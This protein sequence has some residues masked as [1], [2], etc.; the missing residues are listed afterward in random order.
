MAWTTVE[1]WS[2]RVWVSAKGKRTFFIRAVMNGKKYGISTGCS[3][4]RAAL[5][6]L[7]KFERDPDSYGRPRSSVVLN[8]ALIDAYEKWC[9]EQTDVID[10]NWLK[11]KR[12]HLLWWGE[13]FDL[14]PLSNIKLA[15]ILSCL[16]GQSS[17][18]DRIKSIK[19]LYSWLRQTDRIS[20]DQDP[21][22]DAL[23][24]PQSQPEQ[25]ATG[26]SKAIDEDDF[27]KVLPLLPPFVADGCVVQSGTGCHVTEVLRLSKSGRVEERGGSAPAIHFLHKGKHIHRLEVP[28]EVADAAKRLIAAKDNAPTRDGYYKA[29]ARAC[30]K[31]G[32]EP[33]TPGR[34]RHTFATNAIARGVPPHAVALALGHRGSPTTLKW[35]ATTAVV[36]MV[37]G[38]YDVRRE[39]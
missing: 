15:H 1:G 26:E 28:R 20:R 2:G 22:L 19:H 8:Q 4:L 13:C 5:G 21:T 10:L 27:R 35:Y 3:T 14:R 31:A 32:V 36:P 37:A 11:A 39:E 24:V 7:G 17:R 25:D 29:I 6:E 30:V 33:W 9:L 12:R 16:D 18:A 34:F 23:P 38:G